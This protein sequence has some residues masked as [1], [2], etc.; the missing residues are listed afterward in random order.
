[1]DDPSAEHPLSVLRRLLNQDSAGSSSGLVPAA[2]LAPRR[3]VPATPPGVAPIGPVIRIPWQS[4]DP[5]EWCVHDPTKLD[6]W[7]RFLSAH[8]P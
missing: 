3:L 7:C 6:G 2:P 1:M 8:F 4:P 5:T